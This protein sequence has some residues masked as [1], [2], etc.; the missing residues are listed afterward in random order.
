MGPQGASRA[1]ERHWEI[2]GDHAS[3]GG[4]DSC[5]CTGVVSKR[6]DAWLAKLGINYTIR[7]GL[8][9]KSALL[10]TARILRCFQW[11]KVKIK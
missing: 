7:T 8:L 6:L 5:W 2:M 9:Q 4:S 11:G 3:R 10:G 1:E